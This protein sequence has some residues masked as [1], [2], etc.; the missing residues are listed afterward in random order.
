MDY[1]TL[2]NTLPEDIMCFADYMSSKYN[3]YGFTECSIDGNKY[4]VSLENGLYTVSVIG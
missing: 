4:K 2:K 1:E 3:K